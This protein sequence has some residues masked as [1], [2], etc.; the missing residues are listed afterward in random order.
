MMRDTML[1]AKSFVDRYQPIADNA[2]KLEDY[3]TSLQQSVAKG[4]IKS[5]DKARRVTGVIYSVLSWALL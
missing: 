1:D 5:P 3:K 2:K 4:D